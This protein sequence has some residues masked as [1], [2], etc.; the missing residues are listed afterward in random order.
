MATFCYAKQKNV[1]SEHRG[2]FGYGDVWT[3]TALWADSKRVPSWMVGE[4]MADDAEVFMRDL[5]SR[6]TNWVQLTTEGRRAYLNAVETA[7]GA[8]LD[9]AILHTLDHAPDGIGNERRYSPA[10]CTGIEIRAVRGDPDLSKTSTSYV[11]RQNLTMRLSLQYMNYNFDELRL[12]PITR[13]ARRGCW[14]LGGHAREP[15]AVERRV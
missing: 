14:R 12:R 2:E 4:R 5:A 15:T 6:L 11:Q 9:Y 10:V 13:H 1:P 7:F 8:D 3:W